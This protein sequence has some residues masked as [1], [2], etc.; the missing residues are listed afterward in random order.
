MR[1]KVDIITLMDVPN[2]GSMLQA[3]ATGVLVEREG[4]DVEFID[5][6]RADH[7]AMGK[8]KIFIKDK[9]LGNIVKRLIYGCATLVLYSFLMKRLRSFVKK[10]FHFT[11][12]Y[13]S[14]EALEKDPPKADLYMTGSDQVWNSKHNACIDKALYLSFVDGKK[15]AF[16][17]S[18]G[19]ESF[20]DA[21]L[22]E[23]KG[24]LD[25]YSKISVRERQTKDYFHKLGYIETEQVLDPTLMLN[26]AEWREIV[27]VERS[28]GTDEHYLLVY[29]VERNNNDFIFSQAKRIAADLGL[30]TY[31]ISATM[32]IRAKENGIDKIFK[33]G[34]IKQF[35]TLVANADYVV[36]SSFHGTAFSVNFNKPFITILSEEFNIRMKSFIEII[37]VK[38]RILTTKDIDVKKLPPINYN[39]INKKLDEERS[40]SLAILRDALNV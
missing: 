8:F 21:E 19:I 20:P 36:A 22:V 26:Q 40:K 34:T 31:A 4:C 28:K 17:S 1:K 18:V 2:F 25:T 39:E 16:S 24:L 37:D 13:H 30:K 11:K 38:E 15:V 7:S 5:Y 6:Y 23:T 32:P 3:Y 12:S 10:K 35:L 33:L 14:L 27:G 29:S 9:S